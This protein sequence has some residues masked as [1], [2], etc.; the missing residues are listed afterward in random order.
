[1]VYDVIFFDGYDGK[2]KMERKERKAREPIVNDE[3]APVSFNPWT[4]E[5]E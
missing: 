4:E 5:Y 2:V 3:K 1:M